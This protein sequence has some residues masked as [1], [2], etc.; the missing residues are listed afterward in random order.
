MSTKN[1]I[2]KI[3]KKRDE[4][5]PYIVKQIMSDGDCVW[6]KI[7]NISEN[8]EFGHL[9]VGSHPV[10][11]DKRATA[12]VYMATLGR[13]KYVL[14][15][16]TPGNLAGKKGWIYEYGIEYVC[17]GPTLGIMDGYG[18]YNERLPLNEVKRDLE[19]GVFYRLGAIVG[20]GTCTK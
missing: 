17:R 1:K 3:V 5:P 18:F 20:F 19:R 12:Y 11:R 2:F 7:P 8:K 14:C 16:I 13:T 15:T 10:R 4:F 9:A 6:E